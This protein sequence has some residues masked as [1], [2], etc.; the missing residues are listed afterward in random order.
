[1]KLKEI[2]KL[3]NKQLVDQLHEARLELA[4]DRAASEIGTVK[5]PG[6]IRAT[7]RTIARIQTIMNEAKRKEEAKKTAAPKPKSAGKI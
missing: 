7:R 6:R 1:M 2:R 3:D 4:K 5:N